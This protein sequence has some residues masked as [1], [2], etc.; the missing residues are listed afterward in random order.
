M[1]T[2]LQ[3]KQASRLPCFILRNKNDNKA[4]FAPLKASDLWL[5]NGKLSSTEKF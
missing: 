4:K 2:D 3:H 5:I 1:A